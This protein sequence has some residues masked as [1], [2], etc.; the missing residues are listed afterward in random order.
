[1]LRWSWNQEKGVSE[2]RIG[3]YEAFGLER[4]CLWLK[5]KNANTDGTYTHIHW[6]FATIDPSTWKPRI[7]DTK[8]QWADFKRLPNVK[9]IVS[10]GGWAYSTEAATYNIIRQAI[11]TDKNAFTT[12]LAQFVKDE[13]IDGID[14]DWEYPGAPDILVNDRPIGRKC[15]GADYLSF[16]ALLKQKLGSGNA[17]IDYIVY[18]TY[19][20]HGQWDYGTPN[21]FDMCPS[22]KCIRSH[23]NIT[24]TRNSL[25]MLTKAGVP[26]NKIFVG[27]ASYGRSFHMATNGCWGPM[28]DFT[29]TRLQSDAKPGRCTKAPGYVAYAEINEI[30]RS[31]DGAQTFRDTSSDSDMML[32]KGD[33]V[34]Y[35]TT[36][37]KDT[38]RNEWK[39]LNFAGS[40]DWAV[41]LQ[42][43]TR[44][45]VDAPPVMPKPG[46]N[47][48]VSGEDNSIN[49]GDLCEF[50]CGHGFC[51][52][53]LCTCVTTGMAT[54][55]PSTSELDVMAWDPFDVDLNRLCRF[56]CKY[57][58]CP[59]DICT[60]IPKEDEGE[61]EP[62]TSYFNYT[63]ARW[64][65]AQHCLLFK[66]P[67]CRDVS[68]NQ[69]K[70]VCQAAL[71]DA[72]KEGR[73][74][75]HGCI[76]N[77]PVEKDIP[78]EKYPGSSYEVAP[79]QCL[80]DNML[81]NEIADFVLDALPIIA[82]IGCYILMSS[83]KPVL[84]VGLELDFIPGVGKPLDAGLDMAL[85]ATEM[86]V[87]FRV[88]TPSK[89][90][91][92]GSGKK[93]D[94]GNPTDRGK[95]RPNT[96]GS[97]K[98]TPAKKQC[99]VPPSKQTQ[100][101]GQGMNTL[102]IQ[103]CVGDKTKT[104]EIVVTSLDY[105]ANAKPTQVAKHC[106]AA[107]S[108][109]CYHYSSAIQVNRQCATLTCPQEA[110]ATKH[111]LD[112]RATSVWSSQHAGEGWQ[113]RDAAGRTWQNCD[114]DEYPPVCLLGETDP[115]Y[116]NSGSNSKG[117][118][119][120]YVPNTQNQKA[121]Q[122]WKG[123]CL[124]TPVRALS[125]KVLMDSVAKAPQSKKQNIQKVNFE[126]TMAEIGVDTRPEFTISSWGPPS[127]SDAGLSAN[128]C[129]PK[130]IAAADP[131]FALLTY[132]FY[133]GGRAPAYDYKA[134]YVKGSNG[135]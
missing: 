66:D 30:V 60:D 21:G 65:N 97:G 118:L 55:L 10:I 58:Y 2:Q 13:G 73:T 110:A 83:L 134:K 126:Q 86:R 104:T 61:E 47:G 109:A 79:G 113:D 125:D 72:K 5:A 33:Y 39:G 89:S 19:D 43:F 93:D 75:N 115:A 57:C 15:D 45:D 133:Y 23:V 35:M 106:D 87:A 128:P 96:G 40:I 78:W 107:W 132:D 11:I 25:A 117:Q 103:S 48:C 32:Y 85:T 22:G 114:R 17:V 95:P 121:G 69:C 29:G 108:Q 82:Q 131:G 26:N 124:G 28:C 44:D 77:F 120:R 41:D 101:L 62:D 80:C 123:T 111:R 14:I 129:W 90:I 34:S 68:M 49:P 130:G 18:M 9:K 91:P 88:S 7:N 67:R 92:K 99:K 98:G 42:S 8:G 74:S 16:L 52:E 127:S 3:Y 46:D 94:D 56:S 76:G 36:A 84:E 81:I 54:N 20:L 31:G 116:I 4:D 50:S 122:M 71:D 59:Q 12:N 1:M 37:T 24:E 100:G 51:P 112:A 135:S 105:A 27:E 70:P 53:S 64:Q 38:R 102:R 6:G 63:D 119:V